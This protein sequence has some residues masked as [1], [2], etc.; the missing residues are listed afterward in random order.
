M[1]TT[2]LQIT[3]LGLLILGFTYAC[4]NSI[5]VLA[6]S[7]VDKLLEEARQSASIGD[8][9]SAAG[10]YQQVLTLEKNH[11]DAKNELA[12]VLTG[13][14][15]SDTYTEELDKSTLPEEPKHTIQP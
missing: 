9:E 11:P 14:Q 6:A 15:V 3:K 2:C 1:K 7:T 10:L 8:L 13:T 5:T 12:A 4:L